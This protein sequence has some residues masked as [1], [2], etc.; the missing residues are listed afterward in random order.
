MTINVTFT[1]SIFI[2]T[3]LQIRVTVKKI[4]NISET[5]RH[6]HEQEMI[7]KDRL[8]ELLRKDIE[9][10]NKVKRTLTIQLD[11]RKNDL[12]EFMASVLLEIQ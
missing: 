4:L 12:R 3:S 8:V 1:K 7:E 5:F 10:H 11:K 9:A 2:K 6:R